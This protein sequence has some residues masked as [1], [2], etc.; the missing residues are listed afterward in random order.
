MAHGN[1]SLVCGGKLDRVRT[2]PHTPHDVGTSGY[3]GGPPSTG[4]LSFARHRAVTDDGLATPH[5]DARTARLARPAAR[6]GA[7]A[8][9]LAI[10]PAAMV[11]SRSLSPRT[12]PQLPA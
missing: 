5:T 4:G 6:G 12:R 11:P 2:P 9:R 10:P 8:R 3:R 7:R 1:S